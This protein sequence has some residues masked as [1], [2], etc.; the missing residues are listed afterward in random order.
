MPLRPL[1]FIKSIGLRQ[2]RVEQEVQSRCVKGKR[3]PSLT[4]RVGFSFTLACVNFFSFSL[5]W[6][7]NLEWGATGLSTRVPGMVG[8]LVT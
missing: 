2:S 3:N 6:P 1:S 4:E 7:W 5:A 8:T